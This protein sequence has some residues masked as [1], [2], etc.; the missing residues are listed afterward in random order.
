MV[1]AA[2]ERKHRLIA[3]SFCRQ[4]PR[5]HVEVELRY[6]TRTWDGPHVNEQIHVDLFEQRNELSDRS[7]RMPDREDRVAF[8]TRFGD[9]DGLSRSI[10]HHFTVQRC[11]VDDDTEWNCIIDAT[12]TG[13][14]KNTGSGRHHAALRYSYSFGKHLVLAKSHVEGWSP[15][16]QTSV[17]EECQQHAR[18]LRCLGMRMVALEQTPDW[19]EYGKH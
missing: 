15:R 8:W 7:S 18:Y 12:G 11:L 16:S 10:G 13:M 6:C 2:A 17:V 19:S 5:Q 1:T 4:E 3:D 9:D 14:M